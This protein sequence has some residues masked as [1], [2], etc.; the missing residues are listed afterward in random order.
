MTSRKPTPRTVLGIHVTPQ[1][2]EA[3]LIRST[4][5]GPQLRHRVVRPRLR[6]DTSGTG[7]DFSNVLP[8]MKSSDEIDFTLEVGGGGT[9]LELD[10]ESLGSLNRNGYN[11]EG[12]KP[13]SSQLREILAEC[14]SQGYDTPDL[15]FCVDAPD[16]AYVEVVLGP[17]ELESSG[18]SFDSLWERVQFLMSGMSAEKRV[19]LRALRARYPSPFDPA[20]VAFLPLTADEDGGARYL[21]L[22]PTAEESVTSTL[23]ML[24]STDEAAEYSRRLLDAEASV[25]A[26]VVATRLPVAEDQ[27]TAVVRVGSEDTLLL[28][29]TGTQL[30]HVDRL[31]SL[32]SFDPAETICSR[33]LLHQDEAKIETIDHV[34]LSGGPRDERLTDGFAAFYPEAT[35]YTLHELLSDDA[36]SLTASVDGSLTPDSGLAMAVGLHLLET[37]DDT[38]SP[39]NLFGPV[40]RT[41]RRARSGFA[42]HTGV[43]LVLLFGVSLF[44][45]WRYMERQQEMH[46]LQQRLTF[47]PVPVLDLTPEALKLRVD[48]LNAVHSKYSRALYVLD[49]LLVGSDEWS[50]TIERTAEQTRAIDGLWFDN[51]NIDASTIQLQG[52]ALRRSNLA[53]L[54]RNL[55]GTIEE[56]KFTD[57]QGVR[58]YP[59]TVRIPRDIRLPEVTVKLRE[60]A[61]NPDSKIT[62]RSPIP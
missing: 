10:D 9:E 21:A 27:N 45:G 11:G 6:L 58:A 13:F 22:V 36:I 53:A 28:F 25:L 47:S 35:V 49:S 12:A 34:L 39:A 2:L 18:A 15:A 60:D 23:R 24:A 16:V 1:T 17:D 38:V 14:Q 54:A 57:I 55:D 43:M 52:H 44:F 20:R 30:R 59:F 61:L 48:S 32:T 40:Q 5:A 62:A 33:V 3:V 8:G 4:D 26:D 56:L 29:F 41:R 42:W 50:R 19:L 37:P 31:R 7:D 51:W 46:D